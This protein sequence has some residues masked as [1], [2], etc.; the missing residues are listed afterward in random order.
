MVWIPGRLLHVRSTSAKVTLDIVAGYQHVRQERGRERVQRLRHHFWTKLG[1]LLQGLPQRNLLLLGA[2]LNT[3]CRPMPGFVGRGVMR[4]TR[5][6]DDEWE[7]LVRDQQLV[8]L[9][10]WKSA[11]PSRCG[12]FQNGDITSQ[13][14]FIITR[15]RHA[16]SAARQSMP[17]ALDLAPWRLGPKH[18]AVQASLPWVSGWKVAPKSPKPPRF[19][20]RCLKQ[21]I[22]QASP[23][24]NELKQLAERFVDSHPECTIA[25]FNKYLLPQCQRLFPSKRSRL[26]PASQPDAVTT[27]VENLWH[28]QRSEV[29][30]GRPGSF[31]SVGRKW[32]R[33]SALKQAAR[34]LRKAGQAKRRQW[35][36]EQLAEA[37]LAASKCDQGAIYRVVTSLAPKRRRDQVRIRSTQGHLLSVRQEFEEIFAYF[38]EGLRASGCV[39]ASLNHDPACF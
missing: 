9:N 11:L 32:A 36:E 6:P 2:D 12:T 31:T 5:A 25:E 27:A 8:L 17:I 13:I 3:S 1:V 29:S 26:E 30:V 14:D 34:D 15:R 28:V 21:S 23:R 7:A 18:R 22:Q 4:T 10:T 20:L 39:S 24:A 33:H 35:L 38:F 37:E 19:S 16:D